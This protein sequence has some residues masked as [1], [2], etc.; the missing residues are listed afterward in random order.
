MTESSVRER[1]GDA[2][3]RT[4]K[5]EGGARNQETSRRERCKETDFLLGSPEGGNPVCSM[6]LG[7]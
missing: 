4:V 3:L 2:I 1:L 7:Q 5:M 6:N